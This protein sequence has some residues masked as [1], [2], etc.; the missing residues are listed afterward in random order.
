MS[1]IRRLIEQ[2]AVDFNKHDEA[3]LR[4]SMHESIEA[5]APGGMTFK[6][7]DEN[8]GFL[9]SWWEA[10]P[11]C[12]VTL[13]QVITE[14]DTGVE[15][16]VFEGT[17]TGVFHTPMGD[18]EPTQRRI[19]GDYT[20]VYKERDGRFIRQELLFDRLQLMEQLG[21]LPQPATAGA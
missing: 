5:V 17:H 19:S 12:R 14:G 18:I 21:L 9:R 11:D 20:A 3:A 8:A 15:I 13:K 4:A 1:Q 6:G 7:I 2:G 16:G 10:F